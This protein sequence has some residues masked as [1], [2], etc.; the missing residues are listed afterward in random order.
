MTVVV[1]KDVLDMLMVAAAIFAVCAAGA[2]GYWELERRRIR[3]QRKQDRHPGPSSSRAG[4]RTRK[5]K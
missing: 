4:R 3:R 2:V 5:K 1:T